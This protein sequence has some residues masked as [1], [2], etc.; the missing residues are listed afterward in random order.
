MTKDQLKDQYQIQILI[1]LTTNTTADKARK[2]I[3]KIYKKK[4]HCK[5]PDTSK[6]T[7]GHDGKIGHWLED[8]M[9]SK[10]DASNKPDLFGYEMKTGKDRVSFGDWNPDYFIFRDEEKFPNLIGKG[11]MERGKLAN[12]NKDK[13]FLKSFGEWREAG[14]DTT[15]YELNGKTISW[16]D[17]G[18]KGFYSWSGSP[19]PYRVTDGVNDFGQKIVVNRN[20][21]IS[22]MYSYSKDSRKNKS[23]LV[24]KR[25][26]IENL[27]LFGWSMKLLK[28]KVETKFNQ[29]GWFKCNIKNERFYEIIF[30]DKITLSIFL[31]W[32]RQGDVILDTRLK[33]KRPDNTDRYGMNWRAPKNFWKSKSTFTYPE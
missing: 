9:G 4:V 1:I 22:V 31:D 12:E 6:M 28:D 2:K 10:R 18:K 3:I 26:Q 13:V 23:R 21:S 27:K 33:E 14:E 24:P 20:N 32:V 19:S 17:I 5:K 8:T 16:K 29:H 15:K 25:F 7:K 11:K 30:G